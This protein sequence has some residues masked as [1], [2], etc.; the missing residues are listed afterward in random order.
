MAEIKR[1]PEGW[2]HVYVIELDPDGMAN[3]GPMGAVYVGETALTS[4]ERFAKHLE[5]GGSLRASWLAQACDCDPTWL[6]RRRSPL[7]RVG[8]SALRA[9]DR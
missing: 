1:D 4:E 9:Q 6:R 8:G 3:V 2:F 7:R 5:G